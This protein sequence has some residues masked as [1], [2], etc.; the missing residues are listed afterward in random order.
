MQ[1]VVQ[2][3]AGKGRALA[4]QRRSDPD[5][6]RREAAA[7]DRCDELREIAESRELTEK[8]TGPWTDRAR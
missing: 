8:A 4:A 5:P 6:G 2:A 1:W 7:G 3:E